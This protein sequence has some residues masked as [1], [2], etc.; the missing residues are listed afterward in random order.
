[1]EEFWDFPIQEVCGSYRN[2]EEDFIFIFG[3]IIVHVFQFN[4]IGNVTI[5]Y[6]ES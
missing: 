2:I 1:M 6:A 3:N 4:S 5:F